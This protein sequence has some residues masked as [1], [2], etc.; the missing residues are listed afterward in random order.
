MVLVIYADIS[1][2]S[3]CTLHLYKLAI[4]DANLAHEEGKNWLAVWGPITGQASAILWS[5][6]P[7]TRAGLPLLPQSSRPG[8]PLRLW[9]ILQRCAPWLQS[10]GP[11]RRGDEPREVLCRAGVIS[12]PECCVVDLASDDE[13]LIL[14]SDGVFEFMSDQEVVNVVCNGNAANPEDACSQVTIIPVE[15]STHEP[16][17]PLVGTRLALI[18]CLFEDETAH[19]CK[20][21]AL[22]S[23]CL[24]L[25]SQ[26]LH[27]KKL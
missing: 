16:S 14:A 21:G 13:T 4:L 23:G 22:R 8:S 15:C 7:D 24:L 25:G 5:K 3:W 2:L 6:L 17:R 9:H 19:V 27:T 26:V 18:H 1:P 12:K 10:V 11:C 20:T